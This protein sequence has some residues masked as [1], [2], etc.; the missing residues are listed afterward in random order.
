MPAPTF[1]VTAAVVALAGA[2]RK[3]VVAERRKLNELYN[4]RFDAIMRP[5][6]DPDG[7]QR[8][9]DSKSTSTSHGT[10]MVLAWKL[11][12]M[13]GRDATKV[14]R[15]LRNQRGQDPQLIKTLETIVER[16]PSLRFINDRGVRRIAIA[17]LL[18]AAGE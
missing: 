2:L 5:S 18:R 7:Y 4:H 8:W 3:A 14:I 10:E 9:L 12:L 6:D 11:H 1:V 15:S 17:P 13:L 16:N